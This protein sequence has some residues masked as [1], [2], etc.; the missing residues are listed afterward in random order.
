MKP[1]RG[2]WEPFIW[3]REQEKAIKE[4][5]KALTIAPALGLPH[6]MK[7]FFPVCP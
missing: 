2:E 4:I 7:A 6:V 3:G 1:Q 5:K